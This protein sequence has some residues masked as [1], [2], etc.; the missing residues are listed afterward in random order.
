MLRRKGRCIHLFARLHRVAAVDEDDGALGKHDRNTGR[1]GEAGQ[2]GEPLGAGRH[3]FVLIAVRARHDE[4]VEVAAFEL[5]PQRRKAQRT[6]GALAILERL[7][8]GLEHAGQSRSAE[9]DG[10]RRS[11]VESR[12]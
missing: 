10:Q 9:G 4:P 12:V 8:M 6:G 5:R 11:A 1:A 7:E 3:I 2:P